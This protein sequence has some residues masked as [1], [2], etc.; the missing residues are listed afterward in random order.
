M[1][2]SYS[3]LIG[4]PIIGQHG[5]AKIARVTDV[6]ID[7]EQGKIIALRTDSNGLLISAVDVLSWKDPIEISDDSVLI[8]QEEVLRIK[9]ILSQKISFINQRVVTNFG[10]YLGILYDFDFDITTSGFVN[11]Y[12][13]KK[14][15]FYKYARRI[16][17]ATNILEITPHAIV[18]K[19]TSKVDVR[20]WKKGLNLEAC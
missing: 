7:H 4:A 15:L 18:V 19:D 3:H 14:F 8:D 20:S 10:E 17:P 9:Q 2:Q 6:V 5:T 16:I 13:A 1:V 11:L 12:V